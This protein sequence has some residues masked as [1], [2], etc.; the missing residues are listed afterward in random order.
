M[1]SDLTT[2]NQVQPSLWVEQHGDYLYRYA[3]SRLRDSNAAEEVVQ[4]TFLNGIKYQAQYSGK[5]TQQAWLLGIL[6]H[7]ICLLYTSPSPRDLSTS[8]MPSSA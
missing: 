2:L 8:R 5:G 1:E 3:Y 4:E 6:K 7:K